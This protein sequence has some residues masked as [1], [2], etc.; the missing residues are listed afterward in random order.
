VFEAGKQFNVYTP[1]IVMPSL[2]T[3]LTLIYIR[4]KVD[5]AMGNFIPLKT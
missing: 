5:Y 4:E 1:F 2:F 3:L